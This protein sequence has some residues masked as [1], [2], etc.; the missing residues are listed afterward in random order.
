[1][2]LLTGLIAMARLS[3]DGNGRVTLAVL[4]AKMDHIIKR[5]DE[6]CQQQDRDHDRIGVLEGEVKRVDDRVSASNMGL[7]A[8]S[9]VASSLA[10]FLGMRR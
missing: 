5:L 7:S 9:V 8:L 6:S 4:G 1:M 10:A 3:E 2:P